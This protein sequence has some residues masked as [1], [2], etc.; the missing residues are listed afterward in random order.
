LE[1]YHKSSCITCKQAISEIER[2]TADIEKRDFFKDPF[3]ET[4]LKKII[5]M[6]GKNPQEM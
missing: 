1:V 4:E 2:V 3:S 6:T 5:N